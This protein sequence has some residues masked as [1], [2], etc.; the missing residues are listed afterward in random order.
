MKSLPWLAA[1]AVDDPEMPAKKTDRTTLI[2]ARPPGMP[3]QRARKAHQPVRDAAHVHQVGR[4]QEERHRQQDERVV[5]LE[6]LAHQHHGRQARLDHQHRQGGQP[7]R[8]RHR[9]A[10]GQQEKN[11]PNRIR[12]AMPGSGA[13]L[14]SPPGRV[15]L[16]VFVAAVQV[17]V[18]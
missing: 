1:S 17:D 14:T 7:E 6:R 12:A 15:G 2:C 16:D 11:M 8:E 13:L 10:D 3:H 5:G 18:A 9:D 4:Q